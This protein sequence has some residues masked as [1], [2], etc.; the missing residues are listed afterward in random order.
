MYRPDLPEEPHGDDLLGRRPFAKRIADTIGHY[1]HAAGLV[2]GIYGAWGE[3]KS[4]ILSY[5]SGAIN[6]LNAAS[7][8]NARL[9]MVHFNPWYF[10]DERQ[11][12]E[13][14]FS[15]L[16]DALREDATTAGERIGLTSV[17]IGKKLE[18]YGDMFSA[19][20]VGLPG[21]SFSP[22]AATAS[23]GRAASSSS[24]ERLKDDIGELLRSRQRRLVVIIDDIDRLDVAQIHALLRL[25]KIAA[26]FPY[27]CYVLALDDNVV[28]A[29]LA[30]LYPGGDKAAG[31]SFLEKI[32]QVPLCLPKAS[33]QSLSRLFDLEFVPVLESAKISLSEADW[34]TL[35]ERY[36][37]GLA[38]S[39][40]TP[41]HVKRIVNALAFAVP[42]VRG[43]VCLLDLIAIEG[44]RIVCPDL[45]GLLRSR[46]E[47]FIGHPWYRVKSDAKGDR[48]DTRLAIDGVLK[49]R[50][51]VDSGSLLWL[52]KE[53]FPYVR[54]AFEDRSNSDDSASAL[55]ER[56]SVAS[57][58]YYDRYFFYGVPPY[59]LPDANVAGL[60]DLAASGDV[61]STGRRLRDL[62]D[63]HGGDVVADKML[64]L[65]SGASP[66]SLLI[67]AR[68]IASSGASFRTAKGIDHMLAPRTRLAYFVSR[69][70]DSV[71]DNSRAEAH[72]GV[73]RLAQ[74][75]EFGK[76]IIWSMPED[77]EDRRELQEQM[78]RVLAERIE[79]DFRGVPIVGEDDPYLL[80][81]IEIWSQYGNVDS[82][83]N[84]L[85]QQ[86]IADP[87]AAAMLV[88]LVIPVFTEVGGNG[89][90]VMPL[91]KEGY[92]RVAG[93]CD[94]AVL[95]AALERGF[96][97]LRGGDYSSGSLESA[98]RQFVDLYDHYT[99]AGRQP[100]DSE[101]SS[102]EK[103]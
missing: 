35:S 84:Q 94:V 28:S 72:I 40:T 89:R 65:A 25:V 26:D 91:N 68:A 56:K 81:K 6:D 52:L 22:G 14:F 48:S 83:R 53:L 101:S 43:E 71:R 4:S 63:L 17:E 51:D 12:V 69:I 103:S 44:I 80:L 41:R 29:A 60:I 62:A 18:K 34:S 90:T 73:V 45:H 32:I 2:I 57:A 38:S 67:L 46:R 39:I 9:V 99:R 78:L 98:A 15:A 37:K 88:R 49:S 74:P 8:D 76:D 93:F 59:D 82:L 7:T 77:M 47:L 64:S 11:L 23:I 79:M 36:H 16:R 21:I 10:A 50:S 95:V 85:S 42:L 58:S 75:I 20:S 97:S 86:I 61:D 31:R 55:A 54:A 66:S 102:A 13:G 100:G 30:G 5:M 96:P 27:V 87:I 3:G 92:D 24:M 33:N 70:L 1:P 19:F